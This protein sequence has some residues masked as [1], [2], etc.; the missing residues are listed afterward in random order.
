MLCIILI[1]N[2]VEDFM[3]HHHFVDQEVDLQVLEHGMLWQEIQK[4]HI[5]EIHNKLSQLLYK[6]HKN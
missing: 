1:V 5:S 4:K 6:Q 2:G 3:E